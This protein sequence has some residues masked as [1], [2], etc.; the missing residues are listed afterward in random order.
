M[1]HRILA[2]CLAVTTIVAAHVADGQNPLTPTPM[3][4]A[5]S[6]GTLPNG[7]RYFVRHNATPAARA[8][9]RLIVDAGSALED[10]DQLGMAH[11][12]EHMAFNGSRHF[13]RNALVAYLESIGMRFG[14]DVNASTTADETSYRLSVPTDSAPLDTAL[15]ILTDW[16]HGIQFDSVNVVKERKVI[17]EEWRLRSG[18]GARMA[19]A[20][21]SVLYRDT[22]YPARVPIG[23]VASI[24]AT[25]PAPLERFY[26]D[27]YRPDLMTVV[28]VGDF[29]QARMVAAIARQFGSMPAPAHPRPR[30]IIAPTLPARPAVSIV[31]DSETGVWSAAVIWPRYVT[32]KPRTVGSFRDNR[33]SDTFVRVV[34]AR[35]AQLLQKPGT[36][37]LSA[38]VSGGQ[39]HRGAKVY[40]L[41]VTT[42]PHQLEAGLTAAVAEIDRIARDGVTSGE[43]SQQRTQFLRT[44][45][46]AA[47]SSG[48]M[49]SAM[50]ADLLARGA[51]LGTIMLSHT[52]TTA[53]I[54]STVPE[55]STGDVTAIA[56][57]I[58]A[59][60]PVVLASAPRA[61]PTTV[62][63][64]GAIAAARTTALPAY[65]A[66]LVDAPLVA[67]P[68]TPGTITATRLVPA[69]GVTEWT[70]S[71]GVHVF[72]K[73]QTGTG[74]EKVYLVADRPGGTVQAAP[75]DYA[76]AA[77]S[78]LVGASGVGSYTNDDIQRRYAGVTAAVGTGIGEYDVSVGGEAGVR[79]EDLALLF[80]LAYLKF[81]APRLDTV[82]FVRWKMQA[83][84]TTRLDRGALVL[85]DFL[86][87][88]RAFGRPVVGF[89]ADSVDAHRALAFYRSQFG[90]ATGWTF[91][92][93][94]AFSLDSI[95]PL[96]LRYLGGLPASGSAFTPP[97]PD[98]SAHPR[99][100]PVRH[101]VVTTESEPRSR[102]SI[103]YTA[104]VPCTPDNATRA[105]ML[106]AVLQQRLRGTLRTTLGGVYAV[107]VTGLVE[108]AP[109]PRVQLII[110]YVA[111]PA[112]IE[113]LHRA[114]LAD[115]DSMRTS[116]PTATELNDA[117]EAAHRDYAA[118]ADQPSTWGQRLLSYATNGW[119]V[120]SIAGDESRATHVSAEDLR[121]LARVLLT[122]DRRIEV[123]TMPG[124]PATP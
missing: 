56:R 10:S 80:Q 15:M 96:V 64:L 50:I 8:E 59:D 73:P 38:D 22:P 66:R 109:Y 4:S 47:D 30:P 51:L 90:D 3:D 75:A 44:A 71:N 40:E 93:T 1:R 74:V 63:L 43:L 68:P 12:V 24:E 34:N 37:L 53:L 62:T 58:A 76:S 81:T 77:A 113:E 94:G 16:A 110:S 14:A 84:D 85:D 2:A 92:V 117:R 17:L 39:L 118:A 107:Q 35:L 97:A 70:L 89:L 124:K 61:G 7:V 112:R 26:R 20:H 78:S 48:K 21:D 95:R 86:R 27:W 5:V 9:L 11:F 32:A 6:V 25:N 65:D 46:D 42:T 106:G 103:V 31:V 79:Q 18:V 57:S 105:T 55:I 33:T 23:T 69:L 91:V 29:N 108:R 60:A 82:A 83:A 72:L 36:P 52:Q 104:P 87:N 67:Y 111:D 98:T 114:L 123:V 116:G 19:L 99:A 115:L 119:P 122:T 100:G 49:S 54:R 88:G 41:D 121:D 101:L 102:T 45:T 120:D 13:K 28:A